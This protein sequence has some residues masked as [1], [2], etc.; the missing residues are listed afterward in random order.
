MADSLLTGFTQPDLSFV[1]ATADDIATGKISVNNKGQKIIGN[2][3]SASPAV[4][5]TDDTGYVSGYQ[6]CY[7]SSDVLLFTKTCATP[8]KGWEHDPANDTHA[9]SG[10]SDYYFPDLYM[11]VTPGDYYMLNSVSTFSNNSKIPVT[12]TG[13]G[14]NNSSGSG[15][16]ESLSF[17]GYFKLS[18]DHKTISLYAIPH[19]SSPTYQNSN[20]DT[21]YYLIYKQRINILL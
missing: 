19:S 15:G 18:E 2:L 7:G 9:R 1:T 17:S 8:I 20:G 16:G 5:K 6:Q 12:L 14:G 4:G 3:N 13:L 21:Y 10:G 11:K